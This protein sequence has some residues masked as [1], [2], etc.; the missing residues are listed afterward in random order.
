M[1]KKKVTKQIT[2][3]EISDAFYSG[4]SPKKLKKMVKLLMR[5]NKVPQ[6]QYTKNS[7]LD[8]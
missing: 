3:K 1:P 4:A 7:R 6:T 8:T 2:I 5:Q